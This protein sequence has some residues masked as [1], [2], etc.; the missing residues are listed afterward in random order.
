[1]R[2]RRPPWNAVINTHGVFAVILG[3]FVAGHLGYIPR[4]G[5]HSQ[6]LES[7]FDE[8]VHSFTRDLGSRAEL[9]QSGP[10]WLGLSSGGGALP[11]SS[12]AEDEKLRELL[13][14][15][16]AVKGEVA[17]CY[18]T[19]LRWRPQLSGVLQVYFTMAAD[20][21]VSDAGIEE[22][23]LDDPIV[24]HCVLRTLRA[25]RFPEASGESEFSIPF[26]FMPPRDAR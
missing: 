23:S 1:M 14:I 7:P 8:V 19:S 22:D 17:S 5:G 10:V 11:G 2:K 3:I 12:A 18:H 6:P 15:F 20:G 9:F 26:V 25:W 13:R 4:P 24:R 21:R 16:V